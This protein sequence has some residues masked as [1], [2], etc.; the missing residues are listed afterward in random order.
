MKNPSIPAF[1]TIRM[2]ALAPQPIYPFSGGKGIA[3]SEKVTRG[4]CLEVKKCERAFNSS[5]DWCE[6][7]LSDGF[8]TGWV[9]RQD[10]DWVYLRQG[11]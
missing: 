4:S 3:K 7:V 2:K 11:C 9:K 5:E 6:M 10:T 1:Q 8:F